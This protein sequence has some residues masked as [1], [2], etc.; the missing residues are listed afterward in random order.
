MLRKALKVKLR[1]KIYIIPISE[2][3]Y[4]EKERRRIRVHADKGDILFYAR[5]DDV[6]PYLDARFYRCHRSFIINYDRISYMGDLEVIMDDSSQL[7]FGKAT[8]LRLK[9]DYDSFVE[10]KKEKMREFDVKRGF[11]REGAVGISGESKTK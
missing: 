9:K 11:C 4:M 1:N 10:W 3:L 8:I 7:C 6:M 5:F 2:I